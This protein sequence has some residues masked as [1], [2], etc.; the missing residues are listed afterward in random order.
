MGWRD[1]VNHV[2]GLTGYEFR[3]VNHRSSASQKYSVSLLL[4]PVQDPEEQRTYVIF[5]TRR[6]GTSMIA[7]AARALGLDLGDVGDRTNNEDPTFQSQHITKMRNAIARRNSELDVWGWK[8]P[9]AASYLPDVLN[10]LRNPYFLVVYRDPVAAALSQSRLDRPQSRR[11]ARVSLHESNANNNTNTGL[12]LS[13]DRPC[14]LVSVERA[15]QR[16]DALI[17]DIAGFLRFP[18]PSPQL[19]KRI[20][21]YI[22]PGRYK[23]FNDFFGPDSSSGRLVGSPL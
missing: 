2:V 6:G 23:S 13:T 9:G 10:Y 20:L 11:D 21:E 19:R 1:T 15:T 8:F 5:G 17:D 18:E 16:P 12:V 4:N 22:E 7:G 14:M 3:H